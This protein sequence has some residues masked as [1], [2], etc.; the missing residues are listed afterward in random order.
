MLRGLRDGFTFC[1]IENLAAIEALA[2]LLVLIL[3]DQDCPL[4]FAAFSRHGKFNLIVALQNAAD[5][6]VRPSTTH[7]NGS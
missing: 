6:I 1:G 4:V 2:V 3:R 5:S 7:C